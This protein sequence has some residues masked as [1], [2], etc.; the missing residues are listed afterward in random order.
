MLIGVFPVTISTF[1]NYFRRLKAALQ[2]AQSLNQNIHAHAQTILQQVV[3]IPS[4]N[5][6]EDLN[7]EIDRLLYVKAVEN[8]VE[9]CLNDKKV[10]LRNTLKAVEQSLTDFPQFKRC[11]RGYVVNLY[12]IKSFSGNAQGLSLKLEAGDAE[13]I[14]VSRSYVP[15]IKASL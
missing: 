1:I 3:R 6:S 10:L 5:K 9:I 8:Y 11:H 13:E 14:P 15:Q 4:Q 2:E 7:V 12:K